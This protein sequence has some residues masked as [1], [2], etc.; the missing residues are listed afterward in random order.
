ML[1]DDAVHRGQPQARTLAD[2]LGGEER[3][4]EMLLHLGA[5]ALAGVG[6]FEDRPRSALGLVRPR[7]T[8]HHLHAA[9]TR[10]RILRVH[11]QIHHHLLDL[12]GIRQDVARIGIDAEADVDIL[13]DG[14]AQDALDVGPHRPPRPGAGRQHLLAA[15]CQ[16]LTH[17]H[18]CPVGGGMHLDEALAAPFVMTR[19]SE[20]QL[21]VAQ[22]RRQQVVEVVGD[23]SRQP[24]Y[25]LQLLCLAELLLEPSPVGDVPQHDGEQAGAI[26][27]HLRGGHLGGELPPPCTLGHDLQDAFA[28]RIRHEGPDRIGAVAA[29]ALGQQTGHRTSDH[30]CGRMAEDAFRR[31]VEELDDALLVGGDDGIHRRSDDAGQA[32]LAGTQFGL[33]PSACGHLQ[34]HHRHGIGSGTEGMDLEGAPDLMVLVID[35]LAVP[36]DAGTAD[37]TVTIGD[38]GGHERWERLFDAAADEGGVVDAQHRRRRRIGA[39]EHQPV[40]RH[41]AVEVD[42][43]GRGV[44]DRPQALLAA[45]MLVLGP[46][47]FG[48]VP[49]DADDGHHRSGRIAYR[50][51]RPGQPA[52]AV[53]GHGPLFHVGGPRRPEERFHGGGGRRPVVLVHQGHES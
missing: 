29:Q 41:E 8:H 18:P 36:G 19:F 20:D 1:A 31:A 37:G 49:A 4:E 17:Q 28:A 5:H 13:A 42:A 27:H 26:D 48:D 50:H 35:L 51:V 38:A 44:D 40:I 52:P 43:H 46:F 22:H 15:E 33:G 30:R 23:A 3:L 34:E 24:A 21:D 9:A 25:A 47:A 2:I 45:E 6:D 11:R 16:E 39:D 14:T 10:H 32:H 12:H 53:L 7:R